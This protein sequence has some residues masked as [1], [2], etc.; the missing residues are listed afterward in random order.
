VLADHHQLVG[1]IGIR[2]RHR[3]GHL[4]KELTP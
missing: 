3:I 4:V 1:S 2:P